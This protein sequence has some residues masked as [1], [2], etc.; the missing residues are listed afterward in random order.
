MTAPILSNEPGKP[1]VVQASELANGDKPTLKSLRL[2]GLLVT[3]AATGLTLTILW[4]AIQGIFLAL[5]VQTID[6]KGQVGSLAL[7][8][9][10]G[11]IGAMVMAPIAGTL[12]DRTR[13]R[14]GGRAP[15]MLVG[16]VLTLV[17]AVLMAFAGS[18]TQLVVYWLLMQMATNLILTP[19]TAH[20][21][22]R[23]PLSRRGAFSAVNGLGALIG[24][25]AGQ[26]VGAVF[27]TAITIGYIV[28]GALLT[29]MVVVFVLVNRRSNVGEP[30]S[31]LNVT[32]ILQTFWVNPVRHP[33]F[34]WTFSGRFL[35][36]AGYFLVQAYNLYVLQD[37]VGLGKGAVAAVPLVGLLGLG[38]LIV[39][40]PI[41]GWLTDKVGRTKPIIYITSGVLAVGILIPFFV[42]SLPAMLIYSFI[43]G[44]GFG[45]Y[46]S[47]DF[48]L[49]TQ[50][51]PSEKNTGKDLG[52]INVTSAL[53]QTIGVALAGIVVTL[54]GG[55]G[56]LFPVGAL[57]V[58]VGA[59]L[60]IPVRNIR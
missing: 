32:A 7:I 14:I 44:L 37:Y 58:V 22:D 31:P 25:V 16:V 27:S 46:Q 3:L 9:G 8:V 4:G 50:V 13:T 49:V 19:M 38:G 39:S 36:F 26:S 28:V 34:F 41:A 5:Q 10:I 42:R 29:A 21:P 11:A 17:L 33:N 12:T 60:I 52:I 20:I 6:P 40:T 48:V 56:A 1:D 45:A 23:V 55:Y 53:P 51:L 35:L 59:V 2:R 30:K 15:W 18:I 47:V 54:F 24:S 57:A 43:A